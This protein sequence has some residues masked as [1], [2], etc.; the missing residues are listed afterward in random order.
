MEKKN[1]IKYKRMRHLGIG[2][3]FLL[4]CH[5]SMMIKTEQKTESLSGGKLFLTVSENGMVEWIKDD[6]KTYLCL[7]DAKLKFNYLSHTMKSEVSN[8][9]SHK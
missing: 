7:P 1:K 5:L 6:E 2:E 8:L 4:G 9:V 3:R